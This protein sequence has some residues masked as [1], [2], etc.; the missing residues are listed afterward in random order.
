MYLVLLSDI[1]HWTS[2]RTMRR[3]RC[4]T[5]EDIDE[6]RQ[7]LVDR[8]HQNELDSLKEF[9]KV[10]MKESVSETIKTAIRREEFE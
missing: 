9:M 5:T 8:L 3:P 10:S 7:S 1:Y 4:N 2:N 6:K